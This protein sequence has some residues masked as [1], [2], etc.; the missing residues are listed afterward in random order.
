MVRVRFAPSPTGYLHI[1]NVRSAMYGF[2][3]ARATGGD[4]LLRIEDTDRSRLVPDAVDVIMESLRWLGIDWD[5]GPD[6]GGP[7]GPYVQS[8]RLPLYHEYANKLVAQGKA[9]KCFCTPERLDGLRKAQEAAKKATGYDRRCRDLALAEQGEY[10][11]QGLPFV[12]RFKMPMRGTIVYRDLLR[13]ESSV[14]SGTL[15][16][17]VL[18]KS[19]GFPTYHM[20]SIVD[21]HLMEITHVLRGAEWIPSTPRHALLYQAFGW[22]PPVFCHLPLILS[23]AGGKLSKR[24]GAVT[25]LEYRDRGYLPEA[26]FNFLLLLGWNADSATEIFDDREKLIEIF[27]IKRINASPAAFSPEKLDWFNGVYIRK[28]PLEE[29]AQ[30]CLPFLQSSGL[31]GKPAQDKEYRYLIRILPLVRERMKLLTDIPDLTGYFFRDEVTIENPPDLIP[32]HTEK[33]GVVTVLDQAADRLGGL[34]DFSEPALEDE[35]RALTEELKLTTGQVFMPLRVAVTGR[36]ASPGLFET[37]AAVGKERVVKR[38]KNALKVLEKT[39]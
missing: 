19:D 1:G 8:E 27:D 4:F 37:L 12:I 3:Y 35:L 25:I 7:C 26:V 22:E 16:D 28:L 29:L 21:D 31:I 10:E 38:L 17:F 15:D 20:A 34:A 9:Y 39:S 11:R 5:E 36:T 18:I 13:G 33:A 30:R 32:K 24:D 2:L 6:K 23:P 14:E